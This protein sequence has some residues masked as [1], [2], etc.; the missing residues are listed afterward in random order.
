MSILLRNLIRWLEETSSL[1]ILC[2]D[3]NFALPHLARV[4]PTLQRWWGANGVRFLLQPLRQGDD[5]LNFLASPCTICVKDLVYIIK[6]LNAWILR[7]FF[8]FFLFCCDVVLLNTLDNIIQSLLKI[9]LIWCHQLNS[10]FKYIFIHIKKSLFILI[11]W[12]IY[13]YKL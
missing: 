10:N 1:Y 11:K 12:V 4:F 9:S 5:E 6:Y 13:I 2:R 8:F 3:D 7:V